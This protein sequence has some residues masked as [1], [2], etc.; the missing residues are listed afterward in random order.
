MNRVK[1]YTLGGE[2]KIMKRWARAG[3]R[4]DNRIKQNVCVYLY[5]CQG[6]PVSKEMKIEN[7]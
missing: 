1:K 5:V 2:R 7:N 6:R 3:V 4:L